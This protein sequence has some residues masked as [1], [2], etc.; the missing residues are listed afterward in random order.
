MFSKLVEYKQRGSYKKK[1]HLTRKSFVRFAMSFLEMGKPGLLRWVLQQ[2][3]MY[4]GVL[5]GLGND[6]D[7]TIIYVL[8]TLRNRVLTEESLVPPG[9]RSVL[10]GS[11]TLEQ[12]VGISGRE[13]GGT[14]AEL[15]HHVLV[16]V[17]TDPCNGLM[18]NLKRHPNPLRG[19]PNRLLVH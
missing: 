16:M 6:E 15:A 4:F 2:K 3:E 12:L 13:N 19:N 17:C 10:F 7:E 14:A 1:K 11:V 5:R 9:L 18:P 8:S